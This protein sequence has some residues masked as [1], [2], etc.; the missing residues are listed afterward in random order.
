MLRVLTSCDVRS[1]FGLKVGAVDVVRFARVGVAFLKAGTILAPVIISSTLIVT[2]SAI[3][4]V[5]SN[6]YGIVEVAARDRAM[7]VGQ[8]V[9]EILKS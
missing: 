6:I 7:Q 5:S 4:I 8:I 1:E 2:G 9:N 3:R